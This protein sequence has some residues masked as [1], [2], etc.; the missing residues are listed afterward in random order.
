[1]VKIM[2]NVNDVVKYGANGV[3]RIVDICTQSFGNGDT[4]YYILR[5]V[6]AKDSTYFVPTQ[7][8]ALVSK[9]QN[10]LSAEDVYSLI[11]DIPCCEAEWIDND[12]KRAEEY[13]SVIASGNRRSIIGVIRAIHSRKNLLEGMNKRLH[14]AD[15]KLMRDA[16]RIINDEFAT[17]LGIEP[18]EVNTFITNRLNLA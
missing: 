12:K 16:E 15:D 9:M 11:D 6:R 5:P 14:V 1:M 8:E 7:S 17:V 18:C 3:C 13:S 4:E 2:F 10:L